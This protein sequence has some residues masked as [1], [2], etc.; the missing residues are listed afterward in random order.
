MLILG[1]TL[2]TSSQQGPG[3][4][5]SHFLTGPSQDIPLFGLQTWW[6]LAHLVFF[7]SLTSTIIFLLISSVFQN[8]SL[9]K[10]NLV[11]QE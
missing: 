4:L 9:E 10:K 3:L 8:T 2:A 7:H 6:T 5:L 11:F 1:V